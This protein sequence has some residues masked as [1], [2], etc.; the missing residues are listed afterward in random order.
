MLNN[1]EATEPADENTTWPNYL[2]IDYTREEFAGNGKSYDLIL[3]T[4]GKASFSRCRTSLKTTGI[5]LAVSMGLSELIH[6][7]RSSMGSGPKVKGGAAP[8]RVEDL[9]FFKELFKAGRLN[10]V[11][12][13]CYP[14]ERTAEAFGYVEQGH[15]KG[16]VVITMGHPARGAELI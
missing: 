8:E 15:K 3:D 5:F 6:T 9:E 2:V 7:G 1:P 10:P 12:D 11:I 13:R 14:L 4:V 16:N